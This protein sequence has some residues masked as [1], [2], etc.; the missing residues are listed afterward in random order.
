M[1]VIRRILDLF[2]KQ[3]RSDRYSDLEQRLLA[4]HMR[5]VS[6]EGLGRNR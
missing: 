4:V 3:R 1:S 2:R 5:K 6:T